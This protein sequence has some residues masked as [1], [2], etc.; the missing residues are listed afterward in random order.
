LWLTHPGVE[1]AATKV[2]STKPDSARSTSSPDDGTRSSPSSSSSSGLKLKICGIQAAIN[3]S[4]QTTDSSFAPYDTSL[5]QK[6]TSFEAKLEDDFDTDS[7]FDFMPPIRKVIRPT[8]EQPAK[9][10]TLRKAKNVKTVHEDSDDEDD[11]IFDAG[12]EQSSP[13][14]SPDSNL[15]LSSNVLKRAERILDPGDPDHAKLIAAAT[16]DGSEYYDSDADEL[17]G[18]VKG[19]NRPHLFRNVKWGSLATDYSNSGDFM[20]EPEL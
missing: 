1:R 3:E 18:N 5:N 7:E 15:I 12:D 8:F 16:K 17:P 13:N 4:L 11:A 14:S 20:A 10:T 2:A 6:R 9:R 19:T